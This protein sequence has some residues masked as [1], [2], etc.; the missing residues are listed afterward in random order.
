[1]SNYTVLF[2]DIAYINPKA[3]TVDCVNKSGRGG[4]II[5][6]RNRN[7]VKRTAVQEKRYLS[8][9]GNKTVCPEYANERTKFHPSVLSD[10]RLTPDMIV[11]CIRTTPIG[12]LLAAIAA[13]PE[14]RPE[15]PAR[16]RRLLHHSNAGLEGKLSETMD[17]VLA[18]LCHAD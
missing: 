15:K 7:M 2:K 3:I 8:E 1:L 16:N 10:S 13:L 14:M 6:E 5:S 11:E 18:Q 9:A 4:G 12:R 17:A